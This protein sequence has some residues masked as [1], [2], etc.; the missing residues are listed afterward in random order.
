M[1]T[2][3]ISFCDR[4][5]Y[6]IKSSDTK[7]LIL[8]D[9]ESR[10]QLRILQRHWQ[11]LDATGFNHIANAPHLACLRS[12]GNPYFLY[13]TRYEDTPIIFFIDKKVQPN[14]Q[15]PRIILGR[16]LFDESLFDNTLLDGEMVKTKDEL[17]PR[18]W[19]FLINDIIGMNG[20][21]LDR[22]PLP[23]RIELVHKILAEQYTPDLVCDVCH[24]RAKKFAYASREGFDALVQLSDTLPYTCRGV[25]FWPFYLKFRPK[26]YNFNADLIKEVHRNVKD[27]PNFREARESP[28][29]PP[30]AIV[31]AI[32]PIAK[33]TLALAPSQARTVASGPASTAST[34]L[35]LRKTENPDV[36]PVYEA[37]GA[38]SESIGIALV[39][40][41]QTS[42]ILRAVF[43]DLTVAVTMPFECIYDDN[44]CKWRPIRS[45]ST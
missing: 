12:N 15:K 27:A 26:L 3:V 13:F 11:P 18:Q 1:H 22:V 9:I 28:P 32:V 43:R 19:I 38:H 14:Y 23:Q 21:R 10:F 2:G 24:F 7:D 4:V 29:K 39:G 25:Y 17:G 36:Y 31:P 41:L 33:P 45:A 35:Y 16:G 37:P 30:P 42:R 20:K 40:T 8:N 44:F 6:N 5:A 34:T